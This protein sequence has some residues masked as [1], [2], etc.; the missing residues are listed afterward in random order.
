[1]K[2]YSETGEGTTIRIYLPRSH[3]EGEGE[4]TEP[5]QVDLPRGS[6]TILVVDDEEHLVDIAV[7]H[8]EDLGYRTVTAN[9]G[10]Q[11]LEVLQGDADID[12]LF[13]DVIMPGGMDGYE[14]AMQAIEKRPNFK[15]LLTSG[16]TKKR[17]ELNS[18]DE[19]AHAKLAANY[20]S[21]PY[22]LS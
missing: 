9:D 22:N 11:A 12:L 10:R 21:K 3:E 4:E 13:S 8:L 6:E 2:I 16:F 14:L 20:L 19:A 5:A 15:V 18:G 17:E 1:M 7:S